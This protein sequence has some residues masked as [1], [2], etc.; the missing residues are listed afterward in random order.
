MIVQAARSVTRLLLIH[1]IKYNSTTSMAYIKRGGW[2]GKRPGRRFKR[3]PYSLLI[4]ELQ[5]NKLDRGWRPQVHWERPVC[6]RCFNSNGD[7]I[8][9]LRP[10]FFECN[11]GRR[12]DV[13]M[14]G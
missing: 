6:P 1:K 13:D 10:K 9:Y 11:C 8:T 3:A 12:F 2:G 4:D 7:T 14:E 5:F